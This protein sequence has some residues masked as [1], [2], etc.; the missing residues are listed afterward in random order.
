MTFLPSKEI[1]WI[2][3][4]CY[5]TFSQS[6]GGMKNSSVSEFKETISEREL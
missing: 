3:I 6:H 4:L 1:V 2:K 5:P